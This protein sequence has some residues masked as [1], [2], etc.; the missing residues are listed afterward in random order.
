MAPKVQLATKQELEALRA[1][2]RTAGFTPGE[3]F[4]TGVDPA[5]ALDGDGSG[6]SPLAV[7][8]DGATITIN[9]SNALEVTGAAAAT[10]LVFIEEQ[11]PS[12]TGTITFSSLGS[13]FKH[14]K[15]ICTARGT[16]SATANAVRIHFNGDTGANYDLETLL[17]AGTSVTAGAEMATADSDVLTIS[18]DNSPA[19]SA[20]VGEIIIH[21]YRGTTF[22]K[23]V[24]ATSKHK[25]TDSANG[26][27]LRVRGLE[28]R[29]TAAITSVT[30]TLST[31]NYV[32]GSRFTLYGMN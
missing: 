6:G 31:G 10:G 5:G 27:A 16:A 24:T 22:R 3:P 11:T 19:G 23:S 26:I 9:G 15:I 14:L 1:L 4:V 28:W 2:L 7:R 13:L 30:L 21:D 18:A 17:V 29:N 32:A 20:G 25:T 8:V 12:G